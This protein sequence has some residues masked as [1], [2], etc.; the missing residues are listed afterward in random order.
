MSGYARLSPSRNLLPSHFQASPH[1]PKCP[2]P[3]YH[4]TVHIVLSTHTPT[5]KMF[6]FLLQA[7]ATIV[8]VAISRSPLYDWSKEQLLGAHKLQPTIPETPE[9]EGIFSLRNA[10]NKPHPSLL[11]TL[12]PIPITHTH[13][14]SKPGLTTAYLRHT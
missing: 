8:I 6:P 9:W 1:E 14:L 10:V 5:S 12:T 2:P 3:S 11:P 13:H 4:F 7:A